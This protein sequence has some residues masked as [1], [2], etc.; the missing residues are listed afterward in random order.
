MGG[1]NQSPAGSPLAENR[2]SESRRRAADV[3]REYDAGPIAI[4]DDATTR[5]LIASTVL[6]L[7]RGGEL[8][9]VNRLGHVGRYQAGAVW[10]AE[11]GYVDR[12][13]LQIAL[14]GQRSEWSWAKSGGL[15]EFLHDPANWIHGLSLDTYLASAELQDR[16]FKTNAD[17]AYARALRERVL[18]GAEKPLLVA[19]FL[20]V[21]QVLGYR[22]AV[23]AATGGR[24][25]RNPYGVSNYDY[26][27]DITRNRDGLDEYL[28]RKAPEQD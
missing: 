8:D 3:A 4:L 28:A 17:A 11:A 19:G 27:H 18:R 9:A 1:A 15:T 13:K 20:K 24:V 10:L 14:S 12:D 7:S 25:N 23:D 2:V 16:A 26:L 21:H 6:T 5:R 22:A